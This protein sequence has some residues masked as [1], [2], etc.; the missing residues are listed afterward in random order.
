MKSMRYPVFLLLVGFFFINGLAAASVRAE[1]LTL[2]LNKISERMN[3]YPVN[4][5]WKYELDTKTTEMDE[6]WRPE[7]TTTAKTIVKVTD[8]MV[9][10]EVLEAVE[11]EDGV[12]RDIKQKAVKQTKKQMERANKETAEQKDQKRSENP[13]DML[14]P[15]DENKRSKFGF[16]RLDD[17]A[18]DK[19]PV[20]II[21]AIAKEKDERLFEGKY[22]IDQK[23]YD[24]LKARI[25]PSKNPK[26][27]EEIDMDI[28]FVVLPEGNYIRTKSKTRVNGSF[29]FKSFRLILEEEYS[30]V[31]ISDSE[32]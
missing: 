29:L 22:Y 24:V 16:E 6:Q 26:Y 5:N 13:L 31:E 23:S 7:K 12:A 14:F 9:S 2:L 1:D 4:S 8:S 21:E 3:S 32:T 10:G 20:Y 27:V 18:I 11:T 17:D 15:F 28:D 25:K 19:T 30:D